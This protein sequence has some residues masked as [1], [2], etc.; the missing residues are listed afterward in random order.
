MTDARAAAIAEIQARRRALGEAPLERT[1]AVSGRNVHAVL[2]LA[3]RL[4]TSPRA[5]WRGLEPDLERARRADVWVGWAEFNEL[6]ERIRAETGDDGVRRLGALAME[7]PL[8]RA[9]GMAAGAFV[10]ERRLFD[11]VARFVFRDDGLYFRG[12]EATSEAVGPHELQVGWRARGGFVI[13]RGYALAM[14]GILRELPRAV[15]NGPAE[16]TLRAAA[17]T[18]IVLSV[19]LRPR[20]A[21]PLTRR[22]GGRARQRT[23]AELHR[24]CTELVETHQRLDDQLAALEAS[25]A[26]RRALERRLE[27]HRR[28]EMLGRFAGALR[29][30]FNNLLTVIVTLSTLLRERLPADDPRLEDVRLV[31]EAAQRGT[32]LV[33]R[34]RAFDARPR[35]PASPLDLGE[36]LGRLEPTLV[37][38][39]GEGVTLATTVADEPLGVP[40]E[41]SDLERVLV[42]LVRNAREAM[43]PRTGRVDVLA[44]AADP[45]VALVGARLAGPHVHLAVIDDGPG[46]APEVAHR[47][48]DPFTTTKRDRR[49]MGLA[50]VHALI[51][52]SGGVVEARR[53]PGRGAR[54]DLWWPR[55]DL[56]R[57]AAGA[58]PADAAPTGARARGAGRSVLL[59]EDDPAVRRAMRRTL[60]RGGY[61]V[62]TAE[63][64]DAALARIRAGLRPDA[65]VSDVVMPGLHG[66]ALAR[67]LREALGAVPIL[68][69]S[70]YPDPASFDGLDEAELLPKPHRPAELLERVARLLEEG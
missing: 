30:D 36:A 4:G 43:A 3:E 56:R 70:G 18:K 19:R 15:G 1:P 2:T 24:L 41:P 33:G 46:L 7:S 45:A 40:L 42:E 21:P 61:E 62:A 63:G 8:F 16:V 51:T 20:R 65:V 68:F 54:V 47:A 66:D 49:G 50:A 34:L 69:V 44:R 22:L 35:K 9:I 27:R 67:A 11:W 64:G 5:L 14:E 23:V 39:A 53:E 10:S 13:S 48:F 37:R 25:R 52:A 29:H 60:H 55:Q 59:I 28:M 26:A 31:H 12:I 58:P 38:V 57:S 32:T 17:P 6:L